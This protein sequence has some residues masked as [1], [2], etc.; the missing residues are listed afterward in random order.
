[1]DI[2]WQYAIN[3]GLRDFY[4]SYIDE[5]ARII[6]LRSSVTELNDKN[7]YSF[8][9]L[10]LT[11]YD[12]HVLS[13]IEIKEFANI[14]LYT[15]ETNELNN[16]LRSKLNL[17]NE[18]DLKQNYINHISN[19]VL[20]LSSNILAATNTQNAEIIFRMETKQTYIPNECLFWHIDKSHSEIAKNVNQFEHTLGNEEKQSF[21]IISLLGETTIYQNLDKYQREN[22]QHIANETTF[23]YGH[24]EGK[25]EVNDPINE[26]FADKKSDQARPGYGSVH[27]AGKNGTIHSA[28]NS[29][30]Q[31]MLILITPI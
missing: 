19:L 23:F 8:Y 26:L 11:E 12:Q 22:F 3:Y 15:S 27:I 9:N 13:N 2:E 28:P 14:I 18:F 6:E 16:V 1:M 7:Q 4:Q 29:I 30:S 5:Q 17:L 20:R 31:R 21:F 25:C 10:G 24:S